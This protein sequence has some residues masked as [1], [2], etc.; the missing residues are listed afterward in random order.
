MR[1]RKEGKKFHRLAGRRRS[2][3]RNLE[4]DLIRS[5]KIETTVIRAKAVKPKVE[6]LITIAK[7]QTLASRRLLL[8]R[9]HNPKVVKKLYEEIAL[10]YA[11]RKGGYL[12]ITKL[13]KT[14]KRDG[15]KTAT[16]EFV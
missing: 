8:S 11:D 3:L 6:R 7:K 4:S 12:R 16:I 9:L 5:G 10:R 13:G 2:F 1:H 15:S 14:R